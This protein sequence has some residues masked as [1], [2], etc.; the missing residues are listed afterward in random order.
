[1]TLKACL[2]ILELENA[3]DRDQVRRAYRR[4]VKRWHPDQFAHQPAIRAQAEERL[5]RINHAYSTLKEYVGKN[6][7]SH[8]DVKT[9]QK[10]HT[11]NEKKVERQKYEAPSKWKQWFKSNNPKRRHKYESAEPPYNFKGKE[12]PLFVRSKPSFE[13]ILREVSYKPHRS[14]TQKHTGAGPLSYTR[15]YKQRKKGMRI[16]GFKSVSPITPVRPISKITKL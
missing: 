12:R 6:P 10:P 9:S 14:Q 13:R 15:F 3:Q 2:R 16:E 5:K 8:T 7:S 11:D 1:M 4:L